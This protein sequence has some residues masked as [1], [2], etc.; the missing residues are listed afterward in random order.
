MSPARRATAE[1]A[2]EVVPLRQ[3]MIDSAFSAGPST[4]WHAESIPTVAG[5]A[6]A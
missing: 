3:V 6:D 5:L 4:Y 2:G 1:D